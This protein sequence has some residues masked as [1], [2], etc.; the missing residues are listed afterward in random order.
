[1]QCGSFFNPLKQAQMVVFKGS[2]ILASLC[3]L[4]MHKWNPH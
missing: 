3:G 4:E 1:M 2:I